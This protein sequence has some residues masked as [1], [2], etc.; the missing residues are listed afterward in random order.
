MPFTT[1]INSSLYIGLILRG[2][3][4]FLGVKEYRS[5]G[6]F[7]GVKEFILEFR[8]KGVVASLRS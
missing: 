5:E 7:S 4:G 8:S 1:R 3:K 2:V 6:E